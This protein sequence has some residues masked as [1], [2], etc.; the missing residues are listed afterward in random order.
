MEGWGKVKGMDAAALHSSSN[1]PSRQTLVVSWVNVRTARHFLTPCPTIPCL[2]KSKGYKS[3][4]TIVVL[5]ATFA[6]GSA[7]ACCP[8]CCTIPTPKPKDTST[9]GQIDKPAPKPKPQYVEKVTRENYDRI[10]SGMSLDAVQDI[11]GPGKESAS[12]K[13]VQILNWRSKEGNTTISVTF[14]NG[15]SRTKAIAP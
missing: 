11:L 6:V 2:R 8:V 7:L 9:T 13:E 14:F 1:V 3:M 5:C 12:S 10:T 15:R 4:R